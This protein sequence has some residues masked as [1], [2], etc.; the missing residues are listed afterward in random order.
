MADQQLARAAVRNVVESGLLDR[1]L[2]PGKLGDLPIV[3]L[4]T[5]WMRHLKAEIQVARITQRTATK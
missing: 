5:E 3:F 4:G 1:Q 2:A